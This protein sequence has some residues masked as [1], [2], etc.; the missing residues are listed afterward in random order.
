MN[1]AI[2]GAPAAALVGLVDRAGGRQR[3]LAVGQERGER[4]LVRHERPHVLGVPGHERQR[5][6][7][8][9]AAGEQ[10]DRPAAES[11]G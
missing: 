6:D 3:V 10:V 4:R 8:A 1:W 11:P 2:A 5:V 7:R 9:A